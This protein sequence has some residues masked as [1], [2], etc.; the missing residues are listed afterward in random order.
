MM[1]YTP[2]ETVECYIKYAIQDTPGDAME[3]QIT[4]GLP[5]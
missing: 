3:Y 2:G 4:R 1:K 5:A